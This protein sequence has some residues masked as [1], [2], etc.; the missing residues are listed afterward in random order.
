MCNFIERLLM[1]IILFLIILTI[2]AFAGELDDI[3]TIIKTSSVE[4]KEAKEQKDIKKLTKIA[5]K[6]YDNHQHIKKLKQQLQTKDPISF[7]CNGEICKDPVL[8]TGDILTLTFNLLFD[9]SQDYE[10]SILKWQLQKDSKPIKSET[11][12]IYEKGGFKKFDFNIVID[13]SFGAGK[14]RIAMHHEK[15]SGKSKGEK[16][17]KVD[18]PLS[19]K[20]VIISTK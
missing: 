9:E 8:Q 16:F 5:Q 11:K 4:F 13:E 18:K 1:K 15:Q 2:S 12:E 7:K 3:E 17:F 10:K 6:L 20:D 19:V 14:Y